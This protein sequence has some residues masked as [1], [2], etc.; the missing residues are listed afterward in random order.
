MRYN[1]VVASNLLE[2]KW[3]F[4]CENMCFPF[5]SIKGLV[6]Q[7]MNNK[8]IG[9]C[10]YFEM[11]T[12]AQQS[13]MSQVPTSLPLKLSHLYLFILGQKPTSWPTI[14]HGNN[15]ASTQGSIFI[16]GLTNGVGLRFFSHKDR[17]C[18][19]PLLL[20][21]A[22]SQAIIADCTQSGH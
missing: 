17:I 15:E 18:Q 2:W 7:I 19:N 11:F 12:T 8:I 10:S 5:D 13:E 22:H 14:L 1:V 20:H 4:K 21:S 16:S 9:W 3:V 6:R